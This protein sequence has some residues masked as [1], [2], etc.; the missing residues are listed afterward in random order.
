MQKYPFFNYIFSD[1]ELIDDFEEVIEKYGFFDFFT[2]H[3]QV[4]VNINV[5]YVDANSLV[6]GAGFD[7]GSMQRRGKNDTRGGYFETLMEYRKIYDPTAFARP[8]ENTT[9]RN[10]NLTVLAKRHRSFSGYISSIRKVIRNYKKEEAG[11]PRND[12]WNIVYYSHYEDEARGVKVWY[13]RRKKKN[14]IIM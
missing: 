1:Q 4:G 12:T 10:T 14:L 13:S 6:I 5:G 7:T 3:Q 9:S 11:N 2:L 8:S